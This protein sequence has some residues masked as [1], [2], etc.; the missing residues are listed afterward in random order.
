[1]RTNYPMDSEAKKQ[2]VRLAPSSIDL[3]VICAAST[4]LV[5]KRNTIETPEMVRGSLMHSANEAMVLQGPAAAARVLDKAQAPASTRTYLASFWAWFDGLARPDFLP[6]LKERSLIGILA[7]DA[8]PL[9]P[10]L[11]VWTERLIET[12]APPGAP[13]T[14]RGKI[15]LTVIDEG[16]EHATIVDY[17]AASG[18]RRSLDGST[19][20][21]LAYAA[22]VVRERPSLQRVTVH[23]IG[24]LN[25]TWLTMDLQGQDRVALA[26]EAS[27]T[28]LLDIYARLDQYT[29][30]QHCGWCPARALCDHAL[31][32][33]RQAIEIADVHPYIAGGFNSEA[34]VRRYL[35][36]RPVLTARLAAADK[37]AR[38]FVRQ[39]GRGVYDEATGRVWR[40]RS[41]GIDSIA[42]AMA[43]IQA[44]IAE[45]GIERG[46]AAVD[47][48]KTAVNK[49]LQDAGKKPK[50]RLAFWEAQRATGAVVRG[51]RPEWSWA[52]E[53]P[54]DEGGDDGHVEDQQADG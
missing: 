10:G 43:V 48:T 17:K 7:P 50:A 35:V 20:Q 21:I 38:D 39:L 19:M 22:G 49:A 27:D 18:F 23:L 34:D 45:V 14:S 3:G 8:P 40:E 9:R 5:R 1:M 30:G 2:D 15:D 53:Q 51:E 52:E 47:T 4:Q 42:N 6:A 37:A 16:E 41:K 29:S 36:A 44:L 54:T 31:E 11:R 33:A 46:Q 24:M 28:A 32:A 12:I 26:V 25:N 13:F